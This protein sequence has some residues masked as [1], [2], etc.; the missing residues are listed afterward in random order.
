MINESVTTGSSHPK[1]VVLLSCF[2]IV[3]NLACTKLINQKVTELLEIAL[4]IP[5]DGE[6]SVGRD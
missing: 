1:I 5:H 3:I 6:V 2:L 4:E